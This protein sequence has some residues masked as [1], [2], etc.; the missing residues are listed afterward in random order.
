VVAAREA[1]WR[2]VQAVADRMAAGL[3]ASGV[4]QIR[5]DIDPRVLP[6]VQAVMQVMAGQVQLEFICANDK[7]RRLLRSVAQRDLGAMAERLK[8]PVQMTLR[9]ADGFDAGGLASEDEEFMHGGA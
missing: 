8:C 1:I 7:S 9:S 2:Q 3:G 5:L 4:H 6:G